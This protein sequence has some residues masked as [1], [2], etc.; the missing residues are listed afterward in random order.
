MRIENLNPIL[1]SF[2]G[3]LLDLNGTFMFGQDRFGP[4][5]DYYATYRSMGGAGL[6]ELEVRKGIDACF[7]ELD[8]I[9]HDVA[10][11]DSFPSVAEALR[12]LPETRH[13]PDYERSLFESIYAY[14]EVGHVPPVY[15][16]VLQELARTHRLALI[17]NIWSKK[18]IFV[19]ELER[20]GV[21]KLFSTLVFSS[22]GLSIKPSR[23]LFQQ[24]VA[25]LGLPMQ[26]VVVI[27]DSLQCDV[28]GAAAAGLAS[29]WINAKQQPVSSS[30]PEP[31]YTIAD[32][33]ELVTRE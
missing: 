24:A 17:S 1:H 15:T 19:A 7:A 32:L 22:D 20:A 29:V 16:T 27:G 31:T 26:D 3:L 8:R 14:H 6:T 33:Q 2:S 25:G 5:D 4:N 12:T 23:V 10:H 9:S 11:H 18:E 21:L 30:G 13:L 28:G